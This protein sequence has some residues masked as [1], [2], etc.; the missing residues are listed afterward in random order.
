MADEN[1]LVGSVEPEDAIELVAELVRIPSVNWG[2]AGEQR[3]GD[4]EEHCATFVEDYFRRL[5][6]EP[7]AQQVEGE[8]RNVIVRVP[9]SGAKTL[10]L[11]AHMDTVPTEGMPGD[12]FSGEVRDGRLY[13]R[14]ACDTKATLGAMMYAVGHLARQGVTPPADIVLTAT[15]DEEGRFAGMRKLR[16]CGLTADGAVVGEPTELEL[17]AATKGAVRWQIRTTGVGVHT[18]HPEKGHNAVYDMAR[19][20][21]AFE[22]RFIP[23]LERKS[24]PLVG[25]PR[26]TVSIIHGGRRANIVPDECVIDLDRRVL[27]GETQEEAVGEV[28]SFLAELRQ[29]IPR[30]RC[31]MVTPYVFAPG[32]ETGPEDETY[33]AMHAAIGATLGSCNV[34]GVPYTTHCSVFQQMGIPSV[35]FGAGSIDQAHTTDEWVETQQ[36]VRAVEILLRLCTTFGGAG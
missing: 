21:T 7:E 36:I 11:D 8:R 20:V 31:E 12:P 6:L 34:T 13:G 27:P 16:D 25:T 32:T 28:E 18:C 17:V 35:T 15:A 5:G 10:V 24:H 4:Y 9:G 26:L 22:E 1:R 2:P 14:G 3:G 23:T 19:V 29:E 33:Q 30:L